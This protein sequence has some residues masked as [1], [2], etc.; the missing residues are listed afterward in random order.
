M[1]GRPGQGRVLGGSCAASAQVVEEGHLLNDRIGLQRR[2]VAGLPVLEIGDRLQH[3]QI[4]R[5]GSL[6]LG[7]GYLAYKKLY[8]RKNKERE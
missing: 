1:R 7:G 3:V 8:D 2:I 4:L 5:L 6:A